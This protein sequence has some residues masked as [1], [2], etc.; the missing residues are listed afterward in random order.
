M[1]RFPVVQGGIFEYIASKYN[2]ALPEWNHEKDHVH[3]L[4]KGHPNSE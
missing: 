3:I 2:M 4:F 1:I